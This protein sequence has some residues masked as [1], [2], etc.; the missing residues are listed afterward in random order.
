MTVNMDIGIGVFDVNEDSR[1]L[2]LNKQ[3]QLKQNKL[4]D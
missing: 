2:S 1:L 4:D 3:N